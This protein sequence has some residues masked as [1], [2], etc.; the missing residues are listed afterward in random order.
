MTVDRREGRSYA[1]MIVSALVFGGLYLTSLYSY[2]LFHALSEIFS[3][4][5]AAAIFLLVWNARRSLDN[6][7][8]LLLGV[9]YLF[10]GGLDLVHTLAYRGMGVFPDHD[11]D[12]ATQLWIAARYLQSLSLLIAPFFVEKRPN[13]KAAL[14]AYAT[15]VALLLSS[16]F[17]W[18][19]FPTCYVPGEGLTLFKIASEFIIGLI[20]LGAIILLLKKRERFDPAVFRLLIV[21]IILTILSEL[22][23]SAY[24][25]VYGEPNLLGHFLKIA[26]FYCIYKA[27][28]ELGVA[29]PQAVLFRSLKESEEA[30]KKAHAELERKVEE[31]TADLVSVNR[32]LSKEVEERRHAERSL[33]IERNNLLS[34]LEA[35][36]YGVYIANQTYD[37]EYVNPVLEKEFGPPDRRKCYEYL[38]DR[39]DV[40]PWC[41]SQEVFEGKSVQ[42]EWQSARTGKTY[43]IF[44]TPVA[45]DDGSM[46]RL[47]I[48]QDI[49][50]RKEAEMALQASETKYRIVAENTYDWEWWVDEGGRFVYVS[51]SCKEITLHGA[52]EFISD[53]Q[54]FSR[55]IH[56]DDQALFGGHVVHIEDRRLEG[57]VK[58]RI[59]RPDGSIRWIAHVCLPV[60]DAEGRF[61]GRRGTNRDITEKK[62][63]EE[64][65][66]E[67]EE[68]YRA[69]VE[70]MNEGLGIKD[71]NGIW[72][73]ANK[74][75]CTM[76][77]AECSEVIGHSVEEWLDEA[78]RKILSDQMS[79]RREGVR[80]SYELAWTRKDGSVI[81]TLVSPKPIVSKDGRFVGSFAVLTDITE[82]KKAE[83]A[84]LKALSEIEALKDRLEAENI[85][86]RQE[87]KLKHEFE[88][89]IGRS[90]AIKYV[91]FRAE[92]VAP[93]NKTVLIMGETGTGKDLIASAV[94][95]MSPRRDKLMITVN[96]AALPSNL[97]ESELFGFEKGAFTGADARREGRF[98]AADGSTLCLDEIGEMPLELQAKLL[99]VI[100]HGEIQRLGSSKTI[101]VDMRILA[102]T[103]RNLEEEVRAGRFRQDLFYRL[104]VFPLTVPPLRQRKDDIPLLVEAFVERYG[105]ELGKRFTSIHPESMR[106]LQEYDWPGNIRELE[107]VIERAVILGKGPALV[108]AEKLEN[109]PQP[110]DS[111]LRTL[112]QV[113]R[114]HILSTLTATRWRIN[115]KQGAAS[116]LGL[117]PSTLRARMKKLHIR[118]HEVNP[119]E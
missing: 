84:V 95:R 27:I 104:S 116:I 52:E 21:S 25:D 80:S 112:E 44:E 75:L 32:D 101:R 119:A 68:R 28:I 69:L 6:Y 29:K 100:Q 5:V 103:N 15:V 11:E 66:R 70:T 36:P 109:Q 96:C 83:E 113:E 23:F 115:G 17:F 20:L 108:L 42:W 31:R 8:L 117:H 38:E 50:W 60:F 85:Y 71:E 56:P 98:E 74:K 55:L 73:Y 12:L 46:C 93:T 18:D 39:L 24:T 14:A 87:M 34:I 10:I 107:N 118:R 90:S 94:H 13:L 47:E 54:L 2:L 7:Y 9:A 102:T 110:Q 76:L 22:F 62:A 91:L 61:L 81:Y 35:M 64:A 4:A 26:A 92:Q 67:S 105:R 63:A 99:R 51:P 79:R 88:Q 65:L 49:T 78:N 37:I 16:I 77:G 86:F 72:T 1:L 43:E 111:D 19:V 114:E 30:L 89:I 3:T 97:I 82:R 41:R 53:P 45:R 106:M 33:E 40:C 58:F 57:E 48:L 59:V